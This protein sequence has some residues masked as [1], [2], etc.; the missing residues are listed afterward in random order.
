VLGGV[1]CKRRESKGGE[2]INRAGSLGQESI[3]HTVREGGPANWGGGGKV[4]DKKER[5]KFGKASTA[6]RQKQKTR[7]IWGKEKTLMT[8]AKGKVEKR[9]TIPYSS[10]V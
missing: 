3:I 1:D 8:R 7:R 2:G 4:F 5:V 10:E 6:R 9:E